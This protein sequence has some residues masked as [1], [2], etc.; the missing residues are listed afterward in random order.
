M[1]LG[2]AIRPMVAADVNRLK[3]SDDVDKINKIPSRP[4]FLLVL[5]QIAD[6]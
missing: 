3:L 4:S 1:E 5:N 2:F 6:E